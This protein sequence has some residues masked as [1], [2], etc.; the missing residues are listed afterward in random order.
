MANLRGCWRVA[1]LMVWCVSNSAL[2]HAQPPAP[3]APQAPSARLAR[4]AQ[5]D[6][7]AGNWRGTLTSASGTASP[8]IITI[9][10]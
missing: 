1:V 9:V 3:P 10:K 2:S 8:V 4:P 7:V 6:P 5:G